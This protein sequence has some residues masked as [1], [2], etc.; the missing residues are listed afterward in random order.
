MSWFGKCAICGYSD[1][2]CECT[3]EEK[4]KYWNRTPVTD[5][6]EEEE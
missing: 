4:R 6:K 2:E 5:P 3:K 1:F